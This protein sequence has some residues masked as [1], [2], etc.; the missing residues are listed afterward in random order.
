MKN[1]LVILSLM[2][3][4][5]VEFVSAQAKSES[6]KPPGNIRLLEGYKHIPKQGID[7]RVGVLEK[8]GGLSIRY[9]IGRMAGNYTDLCGRTYQCIWQ[10]TQTFY[11]RKVVIAMTK[12]RVIYATFPEL[13]VNFFAKVKD[14]QEIAEFLLIVVTYP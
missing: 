5:G 14:E 10:K 4:L 8:E 1:F 6:P 13:N 7:S 12:E 3:V 2:T 9:D 11:D